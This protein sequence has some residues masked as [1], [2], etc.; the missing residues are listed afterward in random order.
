MHI[1]LSPLMYLK[2]FVLVLDYYILYEV[3]IL[4]LV[5]PYNSTHAGNPK[6]IEQNEQIFPPTPPPLPFGKRE[7]SGEWGVGSK[8]RF[9]PTVKYQHQ[10]LFSMTAYNS[11]A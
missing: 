3:A 5:K 1:S 7:G 2:D 4:N 11:F 8:R 9:K 6:I 10:I